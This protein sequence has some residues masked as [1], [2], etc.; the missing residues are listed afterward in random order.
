MS[1]E[2]E[3]R[4]NEYL[5]ECG[6]KVKICKGLGSTELMAAATQSFQECYPI[7]SVG[8]PLVKTNC[9][10]EDTETG[11]ELTYGAQGELCFTGPTLM[12]GYYNNQEATDAIISKDRDGQ[13]WLH[14]GDIG[15]MDP[16]GVVF[17]TGRI[18][19]ILMTR[20]RDGNITKIFPD[21][22]EKVI[23]QHKNVELCCAI[24]VQDDERIH[25]PVAFVMLESGSQRKEQITEEI[26]ALCRDGLP[27]YMVPDKIIFR[28]D[29]PRTKRGKID[30]RAL[31]QIVMLKP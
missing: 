2:N 4:I 8:I 21:R 9:R 15:Y 26:L 25:Y 27:D 3:K 22:I 18:K 10:I 13:R 23:S 11:E 24:G 19:R 5:C 20:G 29:L 6:S 7:G 1:E 16:D 14:T 17:V 28:D 30:Y 31:E 12:N